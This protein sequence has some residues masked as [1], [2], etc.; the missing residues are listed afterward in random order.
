[1][2]RQPPRPRRTYD[3]SRRQAQA[4][5]T[6]RQILQAAGRVFL[7]RGYAGTTMQSIA[8]EAGVSLQAVYASFK[9]K[10]RLLIALFN[11]ASAGPQEE[12]VPMTQ[13]AGPQA[14]GRERDPRR[15]I[16]MFAGI[17]ADNLAGAAP[18]GAILEEAART[19]PH[20]QRVWDRISAQRLEHMGL[21]VQQFR[22]NG[23][24]RSGRDAAAARD[25][26]WALTS[27]EIFLLLTRERG[28]SKDQYAAWLAET[29][30]SALLP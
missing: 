23:P 16:H 6:R 28:W 8:D 19:E 7:A 12:N 27:P 10:P 18:I 25:I 30:I 11:A 13:R 3:S 21:A 1:M 15:Q 5:Q 20:I 14:V 29:L 2:S 4:Q 26:V 17:V 22:A 9:N 24:L